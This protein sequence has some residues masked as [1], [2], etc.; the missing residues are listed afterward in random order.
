M[1]PNDN[2]SGTTTTNH[3]ICF[4]SAAK[5]IRTIFNDGDWVEFRALRDKTKSGKVH[6]I[7]RQA[8]I[9]EDDESLCDW[10]NA[11]NSPSWSLYIGA[12]PR[13]S[14]RCQ[15]ACNTGT[16]EEVEIFRNLFADFDDATPEGALVRIK[17][18]G[19]PEPTLLISSGRATGT[20]A[21]WC[22]DAPIEESGLWRSLQ[23]ALIRAVKSD[24]S[25][26]NPSRIMRLCGTDNHK[27]GAPC[28]I[29]KTNNTFSNW[30]DVGLSPAEEIVGF[31]AEYDPDRE[32]CT[33]NLNNTTLLFLNEDT[34]EGERNNRLIAAA[35][36]YNANNY[37]IE[38]AIEDSSIRVLVNEGV[39]FFL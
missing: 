32:P 2:L 24:K 7:Y 10:L 38:Q 23:I 3:P 28:R 27:R 37:S 15:G 35:F 8:P 18:A 6:T 21:Y 25:I 20:H 4:D 14:A 30:K 34:P 16:D 29:L 11:H 31:V 19:L 12:N 26:K 5:H 17:D 33:D 22:F 9:Q 39:A 36:D 1:T 13:N